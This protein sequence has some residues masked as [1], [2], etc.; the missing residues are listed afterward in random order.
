MKSCLS[1]E[2]LLLLHEGESSRDD[3]AHLAKCQVCTIRY[4]RLVKDL[5]LLGQVLRELPPQ[6][7][8]IRAH[9]SLTLRWISVGTAGAA[10]ALLLWSLGPFPGLNRLPLP[11]WHPSASTVEGKV[12]DEE[13]ARFVTKVVSPAI[14]S[15]TD[16]TATSLPKRATNVAYLQAALDGAWPVERC[17][18]DRTQKC[19]NDPFT[20]LFDQRDE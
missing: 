11:T 16:L 7:V 10:I 19:D 14:F 6:A 3:R 5:Q 4:D 8:K 9:K 20:L 12:D 13:L 18:G 1:E 17:E 2:T 15:T